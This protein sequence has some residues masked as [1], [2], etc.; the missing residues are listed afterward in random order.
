MRKKENWMFKGAL[1]L[2]CGKKGTITKMETNNLDGTEYVYYIYV[3]IEGD[4]KSAPYH[5]SDVQELIPQ[6]TNDT[7]THH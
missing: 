2:A 7:T 4:K 6:Q 3:K 1:V 5:P